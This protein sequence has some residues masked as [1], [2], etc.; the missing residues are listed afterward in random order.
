M[1]SPTPDEGA[2]WRGCVGVG[3]ALAFAA[4]RGAARASEYTRPAGPGEEHG[5]SRGLC[6]SR[7]AALCDDDTA[8]AGIASRC[9]AARQCARHCNAVLT[10]DLTASC[11]VDCATTIFTGVRT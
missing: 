3:V 10:F 7:S 8:V 2:Q 4:Q 1:M 5:G 9:G 6:W 11:P